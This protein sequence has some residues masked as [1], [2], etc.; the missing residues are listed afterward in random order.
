MDKTAAQEKVLCK[1][2][3]TILSAAEL[4]KEVALQLFIKSICLLK[5]RS[6]LAASAQGKRLYGQISGHQNGCGV[7]GDGE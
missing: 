2:V 4:G 3:C 6:F 1:S 7:V 5:P